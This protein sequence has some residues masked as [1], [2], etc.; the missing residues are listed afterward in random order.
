MQRQPTLTVSHSTLTDHRIRRV[1]DEP[2]PE[3]AF[4]E[5]LPGTGFIHVNSVPGTNDRVPPVALLQAYRKELVRSHLEYKDYYF[6]LLDQLT[7]ENNKDPFVLSAIAQKASSDGD[8][9][10]AIA[11]ATEVIDQGST[12]TYDYLLLDGLL[13]RSGNL[14]A[15]ISTLK[16]GLSIAPYD[17]LLYESL[18][19]RQLSNGEIAEGLATLQRGL[20]LFPEDEVL[21]DLQDRARARGL[22]K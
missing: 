13:A 12:Q 8:M 11:Y 17:R 3:V 7:K 20:D 5:S 21:H 10:K 14:A 2:Y 9:N 22:A 4:K 18:A 19:V 6:S 16:K 1:P 15:S